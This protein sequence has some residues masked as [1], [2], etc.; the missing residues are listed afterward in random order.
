[1]DKKKSVKKPKTEKKGSS[2]KV[3]KTKSKTVKSKKKESKKSDGFLGFVKEM[4]SMSGGGDG[5]CPEGMIENLETG[6][7]EKFEMNGGGPIPAS[8]MNYYDKKRRATGNILR[9]QPHFLNYKINEENNNKEVGL[10]SRKKPNQNNKYSLKNQVLRKLENSDSEKGRIKHIWENGN[11]KHYYGDKN[12]Q[13]RFEVILN[14]NGKITNVIEQNNGN[15]ALPP[16]IRKPNNNKKY[17]PII[18]N[19]ENQRKARKNQPLDISLP[20][21]S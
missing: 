10:P 16:R 18:T 13:K 6:E 8:Y 4:F 20:K 7:L 5:H 12:S 9:H 21:R 1:M 11:L 3:V 14:R 17:T 15:I 2:K 19:T